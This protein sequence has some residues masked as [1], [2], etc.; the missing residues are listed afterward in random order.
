MNSSFI[1]SVTPTPSFWLL[2]TSTW[3]ATITSSMSHVASG[4]HDRHR[5]ISTPLQRTTH[6]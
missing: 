3:L 5:R 1:S 6:H 2:L 4:M